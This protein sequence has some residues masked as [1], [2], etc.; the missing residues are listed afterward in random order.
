MDHGG[1]LGV[2]L[3]VLSIVSDGRALNASPAGDAQQ[4]HLRQSSAAFLLGPSSSTL[5]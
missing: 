1:A 2:R 5:E 3:L 4:G